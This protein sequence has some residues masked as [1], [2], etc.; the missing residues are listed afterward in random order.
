MAMLQ[1][2]VISTPSINTNSPPSVPLS[3]SADR[4]IDFAALASVSAAGPSSPKTLLVAVCSAPSHFEQRNA[5]RRTWA[6]L[7]STTSISHD[8]FFFVGQVKPEDQVQ[9]VIEK[10]YDEGKS[11]NDMVFTNSFLEA[12]TNLT[13]KT[14]AMIS[15][16]VNKGYE[17]MMKVDDDTFVLLDNF[18]YDVL[19]YE[20]ERPLMYWGKFWGSDDRPV[21]RTRGSKFYVSEREYAPSTFPNYADG[22]CYVL[23]RDLMKYIDTNAHSLP[24]ISLEDAAVGIWLNNAPLAVRALYGDAYMYRRVCPEGNSF[25]YVNPVTPF[26]MDT[27]MSHYAKREDICSNNFN[28]SVCDSDKGCLCSPSDNPCWDKQ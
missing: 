12:Y 25:Y 22:P 19:L 24:L 16:S 4:Q 5:I 20:P 3:A 13:R 23:G 9:H 14:L 11:N 1:K 8:V 17:V 21:P 6:R 15:F 27:I 2:P 7:A 18:V 10:L 28:L 26:E